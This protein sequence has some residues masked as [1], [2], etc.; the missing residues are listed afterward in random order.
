M[1]NILVCSTMATTTAQHNIK[2]NFQKTNN[3]ISRAS[4]SNDIFQ[5]VVVLRETGVKLSCPSLQDVKELDCL[6]KKSIE[7]GRKISDPQNDSIFDELC[8]ESVFVQEKKDDLD[9]LLCIQ[10]VQN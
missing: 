8:K 3:H 6:N 1:G 2:A 7:L 5:N 9:D 4:T 10:H